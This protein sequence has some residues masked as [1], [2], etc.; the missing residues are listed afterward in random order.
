MLIILL[1]TL[2]EGFFAN[3]KI[4]PFKNAQINNG[5]RK[6]TKY[7]LIALVSPCSIEYANIHSTSIDKIDPMRIALLVFILFDVNHDDL[8]MDS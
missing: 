2:F 1:I 5:T 4:R 3:S 8:T 6:T 7:I